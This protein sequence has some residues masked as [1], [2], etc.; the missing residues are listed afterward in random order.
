MLDKDKI[1]DKLARRKEYYN[2]CKAK[3]PLKFKEVYSEFLYV[4]SKKDERYFYQHIDKKC[5]AIINRLCLPKS[6][7]IAVKAKDKKTIYLDDFDTFEAEKDS[8]NPYQNAL[9]RVMDK[10]KQQDMYNYRI[11]ELILQGYSLR[12]IRKLTKDQLPYNEILRV[13]N[14]FKEKIKKEYQLWYNQ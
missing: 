1:L 9:E 6:T 5:Y 3:T 8:L 7:I 2:F 10:E 4:L 13:K 11:F 12:A 14:L